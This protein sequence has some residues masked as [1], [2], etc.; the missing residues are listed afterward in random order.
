MGTQKKKIAASIRKY[1]I[2]VLL[3]SGA[4]LLVTS[5][6]AP[7]GGLFLRY[8]N[9]NG[10]FLYYDSFYKSS[11]EHSGIIQFLPGYRIDIF[12]YVRVEEPGSYRLEV[13]TEGNISIKFGSERRRGKNKPAVTGYTALNE[14]GYVRV[15]LVFR[16][17]HRENKIRIFIRKAGGEHRELDDFQR[18]TTLPTGGEYTLYKIWQYTRTLFIWLLCIYSVLMLMDGIK[19]LSAKKSFR[20]G[21]PPPSRLIRAIIKKI[22]SDIKILFRRKVREDTGRDEYSFKERLTKPFFTPYLTRHLLVLLLFVLVT[23]LLVHPFIFNLDDSVLRFTYS[24]E[25]S[26][27]ED[28]IHDIYVTWWTTNNFFRGLEALFTP[29]F[30]Y[31]LEDA[32]ALAENYIGNLP[33]SLPASALSSGPVFIHNLTRLLVYIFGMWGT[34]LLLFLL[35]RSSGASI[36][37]SLAANLYGY[38][39]ITSD[40]L[41]ILSNQWFTFALVFLILFLA[42]KNI[43]YGLAFIPV[44]FLQATTHGYYGPIL[45]GASILIVILYFAANPEQ[46][47]KKRII[48]TSL[49][50][51]LSVLA[52]FPIYARY[53]DVGDA[54][55][56]RWRWNV[57]INQSSTPHSYFTS[58]SP[59]LGE[60]MYKNER[61]QF[62]GAVFS[63]FLIYFIA[64]LDRKRKVKEEKKSSGSKNRRIRMLTKSTFRALGALVLLSCMV[65]FLLHHLLY[66]AAKLNPLLD[67]LNQVAFIAVLVIFIDLII[68]LFTVDDTKKSF[69]SFLALAGFIF[70][71]ISLGPL[72]TIFGMNIKFLHFYLT[73]LSELFR[74]FRSPSRLA[75]F[76][77]LLISPLVAEGIATF[78]RRIKS[79]RIYKKI[80]AICFLFVFVIIENMIPHQIIKVPEK[81][82]ERYEILRKS[83]EKVVLLELPMSGRTDL[84]AMYYQMYHGKNV[85]NGYSPFVYKEYKILRYASRDFPS[86]RSIEHFQKWNITHILYRQNKKVPINRILKKLNK[87]NYDLKLIKKYPNSALFRIFYR[88]PDSPDIKRKY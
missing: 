80:I 70:F 7:E 85:V 3:F 82:P 45:L 32:L 76:A 54:I 61:N 31:G 10:N 46:I 47:T 24:S 17:I 57:F 64:A 40:H 23:I 39:L 56:F 68:M 14:P 75:V 43:R 63:V 4:L 83:K 37:T 34:Y 1:L 77:V 87:N 73:S 67:L 11:L 69:Q 8:V 71:L 20:D 66:R 55:N 52:I 33:F 58:Y 50:F 16:S 15:S 53:L 49:I 72:L 35:C 26:L 28:E 9:P 22:C 25:K 44:F 19:C 27:L 21:I 30:Y 78:T 88:E 60:L 48:K 84:N 38:K 62:P 2:A 36:I 13:E 41:N 6:L 42:R 51:L 74:F 59:V 79:G 29:G 65:Y 86:W 81:N 12:G 18:F 5:Y